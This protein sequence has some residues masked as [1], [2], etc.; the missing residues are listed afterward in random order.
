MS[1]N[2]P[3]FIKFNFKNPDLAPFTETIFIN[4]FINHFYQSVYQSDFYESVLSIN[5]VAS[6]LGNTV[7]IVELKC[8]K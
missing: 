3:R 8:V 4:Q 6:A 5:R 2:K 1:G 7:H